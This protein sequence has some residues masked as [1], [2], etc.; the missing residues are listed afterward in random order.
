MQYLDDCLSEH[1][2]KPL[3]LEEI[4]AKDEPKY[5]IFQNP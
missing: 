1:Q 2:E 4:L 5:P 3:S